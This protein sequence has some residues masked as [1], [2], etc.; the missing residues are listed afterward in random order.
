MAGAVPQTGLSQL[1]RVLLSTADDYANR[2][3]RLTDEARERSQRLQ[4]I[5]SQRQYETGQYDKIRA[6]QL[7]DEQRRRQESLTDAGSREALQTRFN[8]LQEALK[9]GIIDASKIGKDQAAEDAA[10]QVLSQQLAK[11]S[12]FAESQPGAAQARLAELTQ[13]EQAITQ[14]MASVEARLSAQPTIDPAMV[15]AA[16]MQIATQMNGGKTPSREQIAAALPDAQRQAQ[17]R[18]LQQWYTD[19]EDARVQFAILSNQLNTI[20]QQQGDL[21]RTFKVAPGASPSPLVPVAP[22]ASSTSS[23]S[24]GGSPIAGFINVLNGALDQRGLTP[25]P[26]VS[27][28]DTPTLRDVTSALT[29]APAASAPLLRQSRT[30]L[31]ADEYAKLD[32]PLNNIN[33]QLADVQQQ[34]QLVQSG[35]SPWQGVDQ[36]AFPGTAQVQGEVLTRLLQQQAML[37]R[38]Q[39]EAARLRGQGKTSLLSTINTPS[40]SMPVT[41]PSPGGAISDPNSVLMLNPAGL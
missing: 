26:S 2:Q 33:R 31:L 39:Q 6:L 21:V 13:Q 19:K 10:I 22:A 1:G 34:M 35:R 30:N 12:Q 28:G 27:S 23:P 40:Y 3:N 17:E 9:R 25:S 15:N 8:M 5:A 37:L 11:E 14:K 41:P 32:A 24:P 29:M 7:A 16:A 20:R 18:A 38:Q 4:D 36:G